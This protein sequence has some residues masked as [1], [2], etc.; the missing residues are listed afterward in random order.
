MMVL[1]AVAWHREP[2]YIKIN[3]KAVWKKFSWCHIFLSHVILIV[4]CSIPR[5]YRVTSG[6]NNKLLVQWTRLLGELYDIRKTLVL[7]FSVIQGN[8]TLVSLFLTSTILVLLGFVF[9]SIDHHHHIT[10]IHNYAP[11]Q[12]WLCLNSFHSFQ[13]I[14]MK[15]AKLKSYWRVDVHHMFSIGLT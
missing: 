1:C 7:S 9:I 4:P 13:F 6:T 12:T 8:T 11:V 2:N 10:I 3:K 14:A 5:V 15:L